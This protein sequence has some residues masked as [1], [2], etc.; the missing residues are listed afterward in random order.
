MN[1]HDAVDE[2]YT[3][4]YETGHSGYS[5]YTRDKEP[6]V[7]GDYPIFVA[8]IALTT[9]E[10]LLTDYALT[11][12]DEQKVR[13]YILNYYLD[14]F[15]GTVARETQFAEAEHWSYQ[16]EEQGEPLTATS[17]RQYYADQNARYYGPEVARDP[18]IAFE[19]A[20]SSHAYYNY[21]VYQY[22]TGFAAART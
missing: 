5:W 2:L 20:R 12:L 21:Y 6:Y 9:N 15:K 17:M 18:E 4:G 7:Y 14:G 22:A 19:W 11:Q 10:N 8:E 3:L 1:W 13:A 16:Q